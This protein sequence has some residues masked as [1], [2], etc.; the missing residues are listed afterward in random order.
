[1][2]T[3]MTLSRRVAWGLPAVLALQPGR[4]WTQKVR[5]RDAAVPE[6]EGKG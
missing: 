6:I 1:M 2:D 3:A 4:A 5:W